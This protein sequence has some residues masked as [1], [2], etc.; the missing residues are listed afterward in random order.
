MKLREREKD[1]E[2]CTLQDRKEV[3]FMQQSSKKT[4]MII[5]CNILTFFFTCVL[6]VLFSFINIPLILVIYVSFWFNPIIVIA[7]YFFVKKRI[8]NHTKRE[9]SDM[10]WILIRCSIILAQL[11][12]VMMSYP[13][14]LNINKDFF[15]RS[16]GAFGP[17][18]VR[19]GMGVALLIMLLV[20]GVKELYPAMKTLSENKK[21]DMVM[22]G[23]QG[24]TEILLVLIV[25]MLILIFIGFLLGKKL[26][27]Y[28]SSQELF[29]D[30][31][32]YILEHKD[33]IETIRQYIED[34]DYEEVV[35]YG[36]Y[37]MEV[38]NINAHYTKG[39]DYGI[40]WWE[41]AHDVLE[42]IGLGDMNTVISD[43]QIEVE[44]DTKTYKIRK[45]SI[46]LKY[47]DAE[48][49]G[50]KSLAGGNLIWYSADYE[51]KEPGFIL[52]DNWQILWKD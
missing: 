34:L 4:G 47:E 17:L 42:N 32:E 24:I 2:T 52:D 44:F 38:G 18:I 16:Y 11:A 39:E 20:I 49:M 45:I 15:I 25:L 43:S 14:L 7:E 37:T 41:N 30:K 51:N 9:Y 6:G 48:P 33:N 22:T 28:P 46:P 19:I 26:E 29:Q 31:M 40:L 23:R 36:K 1:T 12:G 5:L 21:E 8:E 10:E 35:A 50:P 13:L 27:R 3:Y